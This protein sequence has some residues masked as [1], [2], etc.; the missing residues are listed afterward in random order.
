MRTTG[1]E[2]KLSRIRRV[3]REINPHLLSLQKEINE[4]SLSNRKTLLND[5]YDNWNAVYNIIWDSEREKY[6]SNYTQASIASNIDIL[7]LLT[8]KLQII[9]SSIGKQ[10]M[11]EIETVVNNANRIFLDK[12]LFEYTEAVYFGIERLQS[13]VLK[14][15]TDK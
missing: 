8:C 12:G 5:I 6:R 1:R 3:C 4:V 14:E 15:N 9:S 11:F 10:G 13:K 2:T 7:F